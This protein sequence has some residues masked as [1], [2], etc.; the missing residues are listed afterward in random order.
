MRQ[1]AL[2]EGIFPIIPRGKGRLDAPPKT[3][4]EVADRKVFE[5]LSGEE[6]I[7]AVRCS[8]PERIIENGREEP[9]NDNRFEAV[10]VRETGRR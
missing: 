2:P 5:G 9:V 3:A 6:P 4:G 1:A 10:Q 7:D 8:L